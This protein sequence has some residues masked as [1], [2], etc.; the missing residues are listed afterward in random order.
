MR[1]IN[2]GIAIED[3]RVYRENLYYYFSA[4]FVIPSYFSGNDYSVAT[5]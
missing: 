3:Q 1:E 2:N 5:I 4:R